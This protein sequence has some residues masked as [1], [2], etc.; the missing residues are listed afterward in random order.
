[1]RRNTFETTKSPTVGRYPARLSISSRH[2]FPHDEFNPRSANGPQNR[3]FIQSRLK[4]EIY[5]FALGVE[6][7]DEVQAKSDVQ[8]QKALQAILKPAL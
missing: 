7:G 5:N 2:G 3:D 6:K 1:M 8:I 4:T